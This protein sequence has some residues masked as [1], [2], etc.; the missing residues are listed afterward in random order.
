M[1]R[2]YLWWIILILIIAISWVD[3]QYFSE[4]LNARILPAS[5]RQGAHILILSI[6]T[7]LGYWGWK[8]QETGWVERFWL[9]AYMLLIIFLIIIGGIQ[10][11]L[12]IFAR[13]FLDLVSNIRLFFTSPAPYLILKVLYI[14]TNKT[15]N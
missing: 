11:M 6:I 5:I 9:M 1:R 12:N 7:A 14:L 13:D 15:K 2:N 3:Y 10:I 4:M 8:K